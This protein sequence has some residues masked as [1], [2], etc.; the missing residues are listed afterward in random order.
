MLISAV[1]FWTDTF[2]LMLKHIRQNSFF[3]I[4]HD[5]KT[6]ARRTIHSIY[7]NKYTSDV[8]YTYHRTNQWSY[9]TLAAHWSVK[10]WHGRERI[11]TARSPCFHYGR[12]IKFNTAIYSLRDFFGKTTRVILM[13]QNKGWNH[14]LNTYNTSGHNL[15]SRETMLTLTWLNPLDICFAFFIGSMSDFL[16]AFRSLA[17][18]FYVF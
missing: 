11:P 9:R 16:Q 4:D 15:L 13:T 3:R 17:F 12:P 14:F 8:V 5:G 6:A 7:H 18:N 1:I 2:S 10:T